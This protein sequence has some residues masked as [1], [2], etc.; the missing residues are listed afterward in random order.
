[1]H[2]RWLRAVQGIEKR[3]RLADFQRSKSET[4][5]R[6]QRVSERG[7]LRLTCWWEV[8]Y[9]ILAKQSRNGMIQEDTFPQ[10]TTRPAISRAFLIRVQ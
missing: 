6:R 1:M 9:R 10:S 3:S 8:I 4:R 7:M 2:I 5:S